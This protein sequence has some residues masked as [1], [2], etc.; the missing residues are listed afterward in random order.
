MRAGADFG[1]NGESR[2]CFDRGELSA[3]EEQGFWPVVASCEA[4]RGSSCRSGRNVQIAVPIA[5]ISK[6]VGT[7]DEGERSVSARSGD[8][9][10]AASSSL[11]PWP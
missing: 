6:I 2:H 10:V 11:C 1:A 8:S 4:G 7:A 9:F 3:V 5:S